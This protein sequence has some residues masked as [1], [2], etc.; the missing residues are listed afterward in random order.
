MGHGDAQHHVGQ[1]LEDTAAGLAAHDWSWE[2]PVDRAALLEDQAVVSLAHMPD[3][4]G[5]NAGLPERLGAAGLNID[6]ISQ[7]T[8]DGSNNDIA[9]TLVET[10]LSSA[11]NF[12]REQLN[13]ESQ[14]Q[15]ESGIDKLSIGGDGIM[16]RPGV[17]APLVDALNKAGISLR[18]IATSKVKVSGLM[19]GKQTAKTLRTT[20]QVFQSIGQANIQDK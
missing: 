5:V 13:K 12:C 10:E 18:M 20:A 4:P 7:A 19:Q 6:L 16:G 15:V 8:H 2:E 14:L 11:W 3:E 1:Q 17:G 9:F